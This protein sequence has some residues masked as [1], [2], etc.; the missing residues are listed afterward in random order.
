MDG[1][2]SVVHAVTC[3]AR[4]V[5]HHWRGVR[6]PLED[7]MYYSNLSWFEAVVLVN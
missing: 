6:L 4:G 3:S 1:F 5:Q 7:I 2:T